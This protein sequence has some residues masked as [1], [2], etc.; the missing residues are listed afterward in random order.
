MELCGHNSGSPEWEAMLLRYG[1]E[2]ETRWLN[3]PCVLKVH[4]VSLSVAMRM[5]GQ[6]SAF[7]SSHMQPYKKPC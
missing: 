2:K 1:G 7:F 3:L 5:L 6:F 4:S